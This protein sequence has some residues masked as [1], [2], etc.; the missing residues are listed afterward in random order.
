MLLAGGGDTDLLEQV[1]RLLCMRK[2]D[3]VAQSPSSSVSQLA[4]AARETDISTNKRSDEDTGEEPPNDKNKAAEEAEAPVRSPEDLLTD[5]KL[6]AKWLKTISEFEKFDLMV[7]FSSQELL[8]DAVDILSF[9][10][11]ASAEAAR[12]KYQKGIKC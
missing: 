7:Q 8:R 6:R 2:A 1:V 12:L 10:T 11:S 3:L 5:M 9:Q 4:E